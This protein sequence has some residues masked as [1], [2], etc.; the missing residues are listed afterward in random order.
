MRHYGALFGYR[1][2][3][4]TESV[5]HRVDCYPPVQRQG[6]FRLAFGHQPGARLRFERRGLHRGQGRAELS[7]LLLLA[8]LVL[9][10]LGALGGQ[11]VGEVG[12]DATKELRL[13]VRRGGGLV[14]KGKEKMSL[15]FSF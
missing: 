5:Q 9:L 6:I 14:R 7:E 13:V 1:L 3:P 11:G 8:R 15:P 4:T 2:A 12:Q 10:V